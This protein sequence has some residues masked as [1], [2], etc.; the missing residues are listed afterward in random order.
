MSDHLFLVP[1]NPRLSCS[2]RVIER[3]LLDI[4]LIAGQTGDRKGSEYGAGN[5]FAHLLTFLGCSPVVFG[6][7]ENR[8]TGRQVEIRVFHRATLM[9]AGNTMT[10]RC[11]GCR[12]P[13]ND[14][15]TQLEGWSGDP[16]N[17]VWECASCGVAVPVY[18]LDWRQS[19]GCARTL[20]VIHGIFP[21]EAVPGDELL[22]ALERASG[23]PWRYFYLQL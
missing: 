11:P 17:A 14:W 1:H 15:R 4:G 2:A 8:A 5:R 19:A 7:G 23:S 6:E 18:A 16:E 22:S 13:V 10:P 20:V 3:C 9:F 12:L 21:G